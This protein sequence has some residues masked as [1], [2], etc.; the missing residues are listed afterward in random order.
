MTLIEKKIKEDIL[1]ELEIPNVLNR[2]R[3]YAIEECK[4]FGSKK[5]RVYSVRRFLVPSLAGVVGVFLVVMLILIGSS[6]GK[7]F[8]G[9]AIMSNNKSYDMAENGAS[10]DSAP[11][12]PAPNEDM[13]SGDVKDGET[14][15]EPINISL[16]D[17]YLGNV[18]TNVLTESEVNN[19]Y[20]EIVTYVN[21]GK[22]KDDIALLYGENI[23]ESIKI[24][25]DY[26]IMTK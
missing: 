25:Y 26:I 6:N 21:E 5:I 10:R 12:Q 9:L 11:Q 24:I 18:E 7:M 23:Q 20:N 1:N 13:Y 3:P 4:S 2:V 17:Y 15:S 14:A 8:D 16:Y 19:Y 22:N